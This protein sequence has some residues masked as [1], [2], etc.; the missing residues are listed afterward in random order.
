MLFLFLKLRIWVL[1]L[2]Y[3]LEIFRY[4]NKFIKKW[5]V[6]NFA[7]YVD[8]LYVK[9]RKCGFLQQILYYCWED[10]HYRE[11]LKVCSHWV[12]ICVLAIELLVLKNMSENSHK[13]KM[14]KYRVWFFNQLQ[15]EI[16]N[17]IMGFNFFCCYLSLVARVLLLMSQHRFS[18]IR[19]QGW[20]LGW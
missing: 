11:R 3:H 19:K 14:E 2:F 6:W 7:E 12:Y 20:K 9:Q 8:Y 10:K 18:R 16:R 13:Q 5:N 15:G 1:C 4:C 17:G